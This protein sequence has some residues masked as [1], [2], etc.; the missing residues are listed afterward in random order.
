NPST[1]SKPAAA[2]TD[3][4]ASAV[5]S[6]SR[7][8]REPPSS[9]SPAPHPTDSPVPPIADPSGS[10]PSSSTAP[11]AAPTAHRP[12]PNCP[13]PIPSAAHQYRATNTAWANHY[14]G[15]SRSEQK[16]T[17]VTEETIIGHVSQIP[18][19]L[20]CLCYL[21]F[22]NCPPPLSAIS[23]QKVTADWRRAARRV[24]VHWPR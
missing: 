4:T 1:G 9:S 14:T 6:R 10:S 15:Q 24:Y 7:L 23:D 3:K 20:R 12:P 18:C 19:L 2:A 17:E 22:K 8:D 16:A 5:T 21:L 11:D 13:P